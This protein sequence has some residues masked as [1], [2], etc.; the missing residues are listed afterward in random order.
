MYTIDQ[1]KNAVKKRNF[2]YFEGVKDFDLNI[3]GVRNMAPGRKVT[4]VFDD[5]L[6]VTY[7]EKGVWK[8]ESWPITTDPGTKAVKQFKNPRGVARLIPGQ[9]RSSFEI[10]KH[11]GKYD[12]ICQVLPVKVWRDKNKDMTFD[13]VEIQ[14]GIFGINIHRSNPVTES[15]YVE[16]WSEG[17]QVFKRV[18]DFNRFMYLCNEARKIHGNRFT[19]TLLTTKDFQ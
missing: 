3:I 2:V 1:V 9:Y 8:I 13:E 14:E 16:N 17:C 5:T 12:A 19:Y 11:Q 18:K 15:Q 7:K 10:R 6:V 4:N